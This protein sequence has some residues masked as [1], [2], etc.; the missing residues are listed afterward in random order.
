MAAGG[1]VVCSGG[2]PL[3]SHRSECGWRAPCICM[4]LAP[5]TR[6][7]RSPLPTGQLNGLRMWQEATMYSAFKHV[8]AA[9]E[10]KNVTL[11]PTQTS[12]AYFCPLAEAANASDPMSAAAP[13]CGVRG[14]RGGA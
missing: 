13:F 3:R 7:L 6:P 11:S 1:T 14:A 10:A 5:R 2:A 12:P 8:F 4:K 9:A